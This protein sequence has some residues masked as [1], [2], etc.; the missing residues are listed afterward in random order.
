MRELI[1]FGVAAMLAV[2]AT[3]TASAQPP[4][5]PS[6]AIRADEATQVATGWTLVTE[7][8]HAEAAQL[9]AQ[10][11]AQNP[12]SVPALSLLIEAD[13]AR[14]GS[15][16]AL[17]SYESWL[18]ARTLE[19]PGI[20]RR[21]ARAMLHEFARQER[22]VAARAESLKALVAEGDP[23]ALFVMRASARGSGE[24]DVRT[25]AALGDA[26]AIDRVAA[27]LKTT[28]GLKLREIRVLGESRS[29]KAAAPLVAV[30]TD[31][32]P[33]NRAQAAD[34][35][36]RLDRPDVVPHL[37]ALLTDAHGQVRLAAAGALFRMGD[38][39]GEAIIR[40]LAV[41]QNVA[42]R[43][44]AALL[45]ASRPDE[46]WK[47][48]VRELST[49]PDGVVRLDAARL[50]A[51]HDPELARSIFET[52]RTDENLAIREETELTLA[53]S[54]ISG[55]SALRQFLRTGSGLVKVRAAAR[56][57]AMTR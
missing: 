38:M 29:A 32:M 1:K 8:K 46:A 16:T 7:G 12:R 25:L 20:L 35:L 30:L 5:M 2:V 37:K 13:I 21:I 55:F 48:L 28:P 34:A 24:N 18:G 52:L 54:P 41:S 42:E 10:V 14:A 27:Q 15:S 36:G 53:H 50:L 47:A 33:Q 44:T 3:G 40:E 4:P 26:E 11:L 22:D 51:E 49:V 39:S 43:R 9:A 57:L 45:L 19:E 6:S 56:L 31:P 17:A 23:D